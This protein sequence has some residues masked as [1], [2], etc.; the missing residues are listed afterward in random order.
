MASPHGGAIFLLGRRASLVNEPSEFDRLKTITGAQRR[1]LIGADHVQDTMHV[2]NTVGATKA[3]IDGVGNA[4]RLTVE[5]VIPQPIPVPAFE[6][7]AGDMVVDERLK[8]DRAT[9]AHRTECA[10][11]TVS[12]EQ[13]VD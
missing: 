1:V 3:E 10:R 13:M 4:V 2:W 12:V 6:C 7:L 11:V 9:V 5:E 8:P